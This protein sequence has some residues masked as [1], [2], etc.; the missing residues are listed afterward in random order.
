MDS[1][2]HVL[3]L[4]T[5]ELEEGYLFMS[6]LKILMMQVSDAEIIVNDDCNL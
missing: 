2:W 4:L 5:L 6:H 1:S 3:F